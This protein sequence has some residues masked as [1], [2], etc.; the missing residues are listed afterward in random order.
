MKQLKDVGVA[1]IGDPIENQGN[2]LA[3]FADRDGN[4]LHL[5]SRE[6]PLP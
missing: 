3:F 1:I 6:T 4:L 5:V 2:R